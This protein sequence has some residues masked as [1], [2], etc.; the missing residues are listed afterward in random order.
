[1]RTNPKRITNY[2]W[3]RNSTTECTQTRSQQ[4]RGRLAPLLRRAAITVRSTGQRHRRVSLSAELGANL[5]EYTLLISLIVLLVVV[6]TR[7][8]REPLR[9][10]LSTVSSAV[11]AT[12][13]GAG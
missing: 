12:T 4:I 2:R 9:D 6:V 13:E 8:T 5:V 11:E 7:V 1:M 3:V 10:S